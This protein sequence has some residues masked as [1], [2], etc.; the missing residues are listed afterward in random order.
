M[1]RIEVKFAPDDVDAKTGEFSGYG[2]VFGNTDSY[3]DVIVAGAFKS[4]LRAWRKEKKLPP[5]LV[6]HGGWMMSDMDAIPIGVWTEMEE[7]DHGLK[8][9]GRLIALDTDRGKTIYG[10]MKEGAL[11]G[12]SIG[13]RAKRFSIGTKP[14]EPRRK[15]EEIDLIEV[16][17]V[18]FPANGKAR[19]G[20]V[21][22]AR[23]LENL[24]AK[25]SATWMPPSGRKICRRETPRRLS[26]H[27]RN[28]SSG[29]LGRRVRILA[30]RMLRQRSWR[31]RS[32]GTSTPFRCEDEHERRDQAAD[33]G[34]GPRLRRLQEGG[35]GEVG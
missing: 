30:T 13:Y 7:D 23:D 28:G 14:D 32:A 20:A 18:T 26:R 34:S 17:V 10:A 27:S 24:T 33:R 29:T 31:K 6:Q 3:G 12:M 21:K 5:M 16:S 1:D 11:D 9:K 4:T 22:S 8:V 35:R 25:I 19:V 2:A 15:L